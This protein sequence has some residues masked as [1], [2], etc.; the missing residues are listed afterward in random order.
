VLSVGGSPGANGSAGAEQEAVKEEQ[1]EFDVVLSGFEA[2]VNQS[3][4]SLQGFTSNA[5]SISFKVSN[6][7]SNSEDLN[8][9]PGA[10]RL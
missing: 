1:T 6:S 2:K 7:S 3:I 8:I 9:F 10:F 4:T 5:H